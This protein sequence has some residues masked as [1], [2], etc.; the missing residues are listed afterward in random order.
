LSLALFSLAVAF[1]FSRIS[2]HHHLLQRPST[3]ASSAS[4]F[5][6]VISH[7]SFFGLFVQSKKGIL[8]RRNINLSLNNVISFCKRK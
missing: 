6:P 8:S 7:I 1:A 5:P 3:C 2:H 4:I